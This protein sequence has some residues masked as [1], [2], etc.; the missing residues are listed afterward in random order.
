MVRREIFGP[1]RGRD[2]VPV[3]EDGVATVYGAGGGASGRKPV[4]AHRLAAQIPPGRLDQLSF[5]VRCKP[6]DRWNEAVGWGRDSGHQALENWRPDGLRGDPERAH[7]CHDRPPHEGEGFAVEAQ[8]LSAAQLVAYAAPTMALQAMMVP[9]LMY[10]GDLSRRW[11]AVAPRPW[12]DVRD[13]LRF[14]AFRSAD[15]RVVRPGPPWPSA[16]ATDGCAVRRS[17]S[18]FAT[19]FLLPEP[20]LGLFCWSGCWCSTSVD[21]GFHSGTDTGR[22]AHRRL[23][24]S[25]RA[26]RRLPRDRLSSAYPPRPSCRW[27]T[28]R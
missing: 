17:R 25:A 28:C 18:S 1:D 27:S 11:R 7:R 10:P 20:G 14:E 5:H 3:L 21:D 15:R 4:A 8:T 16:A 13:R 19:Y 24:T 2:A 9:L 23:I 26:H 22:R 6:A 12:C